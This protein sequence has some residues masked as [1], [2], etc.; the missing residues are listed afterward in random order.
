MLRPWEPPLAFFRDDEYVLP[1]PAFQ[2]MTEPFM[3]RCHAPAHPILLDRGPGEP[4]RLR[5]VRQLDR[6]AHRHLGLPRHGTDCLR[7]V[8]RR[9]S[10]RSIWRVAPRFRLWGSAWSPRPR[11]GH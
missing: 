10:I 9:P 7:T 5:H 3:R 2:I 8:R 6:A 1:H 4:D 11:R